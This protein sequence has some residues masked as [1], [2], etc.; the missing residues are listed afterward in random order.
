MPG[1]TAPFVQV[2]ETI[3]EYT[4]T[5]DDQTTIQVPL[6]LP[7]SVSNGG[8][9]IVENGQRYFMVSNGDQYPSYSKASAD[10]ITSRQL[11]IERHLQFHDNLGL[12]RDTISIDGS[13]DVHLRQAPD[14]DVGKILASKSCL[15]VD[16]V[17]YFFYCFLRG[18]KYL[19]S[20]G[21]A[22][23]NLRW[24]CVSAT[25]NEDVFI[26]DFSDAR[27]LPASG[28]NPDLPQAAVMLCQLFARNQTIYT[29]E[30]PT[31]L[32]Y[33]KIPDT[34]ARNLFHCL[35]S[36]YYSAAD[37]LAHPFL[38]LLREETDE[39]SCTSAFNW[40]DWEPPE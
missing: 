9:G 36:G 8:K 16:H 21:I 30:L 23:C 37:A 33:M 24:D 25:S 1:S 29:T 35:K 26:N 18:L 22:H 28:R 31:A 40:S 27:P 5:F 12:I 14:T 20:S 11:A 32:Q 3:R 7:Y 39:P 17:E 15:T 10:T 2:S 34:E 19:H 6:T 4:V 38:K 13:P